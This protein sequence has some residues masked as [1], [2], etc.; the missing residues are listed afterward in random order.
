MY[1][2]TVLQL[3]RIET[4]TEQAPGGF[5]DPYDKVIPCFPRDNPRVARVPPAYVEQK[6]TWNEALK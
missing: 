6:Y 3:E 5:Q 1:Q 2:V 4:K